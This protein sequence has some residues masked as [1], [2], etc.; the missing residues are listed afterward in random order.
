MDEETF[1]T[2][3]ERESYSA[4]Y[5]KKLRAEASSY[6]KELSALKR[7]E[8]QK[9]AETKAAEEQRLAEQ[10]QWQELA[11]R[12]ESELAQASAEAKAKGEALERYQAT[13]TK[14]LEERRKA[15]P[16]HVLALLDKLDPV[17][18]LAYIAENEAEFAKPQGAGFTPPKRSSTP[19]SA[20]S[21]RPLSL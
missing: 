10:Q 4:A 18:Q 3:E 8:A 17:D 21:G 5:V 13:L 16:K 9:Q 20:P 11:K 12:R 1:G 7:A 14:L 19:A 6:H 2:D 15:V